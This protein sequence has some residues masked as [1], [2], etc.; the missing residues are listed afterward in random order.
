MQFRLD[1]QLSAAEGAVIRVLGMIERRGFTASSIHADRASDGTWQLSMTI[2]GPRPG[3]TLAHQL[4]KIHDCL[5]VSV[6]PVAAGTD[7]AA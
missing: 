3:Q 7:A 1:L 5:Q 6:Q 2:A 4:E